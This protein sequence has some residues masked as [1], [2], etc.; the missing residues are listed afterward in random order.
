MPG[1]VLGEAGDL[2]LTTNRHA[3]LLDPAEQDPLDVALRQPKGVR[4]P[5]GEAAE[6]QRGVAEAQR[7]G[8]LSLGEEP[9][10]DAALVEDLDRS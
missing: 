7:L 5:G 2:E 3:Q 8:R 9:A 1:V 6:V 4:M 10:C